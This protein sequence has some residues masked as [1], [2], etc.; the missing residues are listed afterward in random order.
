MVLILKGEAALFFG[1]FGHKR[2]SWAGKYILFTEKG[3]KGRSHGIG[4]FKPKPE[5]DGL[6]DVASQS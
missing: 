2:A 5:G 1:S 3:S 4:I 6:T